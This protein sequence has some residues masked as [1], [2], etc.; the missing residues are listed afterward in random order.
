MIRRV[1]RDQLSKFS[2]ARYWLLS[3]AHSLSTSTDVSDTSV[4]QPE[5]AP[6]QRRTKTAPQQQQQQQ[7]KQHR[8]RVHHQS[9]KQQ[10]QAEQEQRTVIV[11]VV[12][13]P[14]A[15]KST[16]TNRLIGHK[17]SGV[18]SKRNTTV[19]PQLGS[20]NVGSTQVSSSC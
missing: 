5:K 14:N 8:P 1:C 19:D 7:Q 4:D 20:F 13:L 16:L 17:I 9:R 3:T 18:S 6:E 2:C 15:G 10:V 12:G 11:A